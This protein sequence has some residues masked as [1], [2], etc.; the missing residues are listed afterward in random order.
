MILASGIVLWNCSNVFSTDVRTVQY[1]GDDIL[2]V[3]V[4]MNE[5]TIKSLAECTV[6]H[7]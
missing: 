1:A 5:N 3:A 7:A 6:D 2:W 4:R